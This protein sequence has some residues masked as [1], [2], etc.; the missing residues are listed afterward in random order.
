LNDPT[1]RNERDVVIFTDTFRIEGK[2]NIFS[3]VRLTD[4]MNESKPFVAITDATI[5][6]LSD[7][8]VM[9][10]AFLNIKLDAIQI[11]VPS[12]DA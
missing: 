5:K 11:I 8:Q 9:T 2:L 1:V 4:Y 12:D 7:R 10:A 6:D 3:G